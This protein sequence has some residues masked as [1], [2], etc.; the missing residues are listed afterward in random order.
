MNSTTQYIVVGRSSE[1]EQ[2][3]L[4]NQRSKLTIRDVTREVALEVQYAGQAKSPM[5][6]ISAGFNANTEI[7][8][9]DWGVNWNVFLETGGVLV[10]DQVNISMEIEPIKQPVPVA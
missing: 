5:G 8:R 6:T 10:A 1:L 4:V 2:Q 9:K 3:R 7:N